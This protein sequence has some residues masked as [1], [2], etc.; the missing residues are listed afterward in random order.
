MS[1]MAPIHTHD[2]SDVIHVESNANR[3]YTFDQFLDIWRLDL[4][5]K[6]IQVSVNGKPLNKL[7]YVL[8]D[9]DDIVMEVKQQ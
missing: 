1:G 4:N 9:S 5:D 3:N 2:S 6:A 8:K 7:S